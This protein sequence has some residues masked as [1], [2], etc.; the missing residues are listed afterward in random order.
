LAGSGRCKSKQ[1]EHKNTRKGWKKKCKNAVTRGKGQETE[2]EGKIEKNRGKKAPPMN[3][4]GHKNRIEKTP[5]PPF[6]K[7]KR[8]KGGKILGGRNKL[9]REPLDQEIRM[10]SVKEGGGK[11]GGGT[12]PG[13][14]S[15]K[16]KL[17]KTKQD[18]KEFS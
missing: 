4:K 16:E 7:K 13:E 9:I 14:V 8:Y 5:I 12:D 17:S 11:G 1:R 18:T 3:E 6:D 2:D 10:P 15:D